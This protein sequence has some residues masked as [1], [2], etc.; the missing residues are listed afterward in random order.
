MQ[1]ST[2]IAQDPLRIVHVVDSLERGGMERVVTDLAIAQRAAG[3]VVTVFS[4]NDT[5]GF[6]SELRLAGVPVIVAGKRRSF[7]FSVLRQLRDIAV[8]GRTHI[9]HAHNFTPNYYCAAA[10]LG[11]RQAP[12][13][14]VTCHDMGTRLSNRKLRLF[15][16]LSLTKT[17][18]V[19]MV[20]RQV[21]DRYVESGMVGA[22]RA[23]TIMSGVPLERFDRSESRRMRAFQ[24]LDLPPAA[25][26]IGCVGRLV[27]IKNHRLLLDALPA[28]LAAHSG[29]VLVLVG[30]GELE[31]PL[32]AQA[33]A[34]QLDSK[35][36]FVGE[37]GDVAD[38]LPAFDIFVLPSSS[39]GLSIALLEAC[40]S[41]CAVVATEVGGNPQI[42]QHG[43]NGL[44]VPPGD[45]ASLRAALDELLTD[46]ARRA[47]FGAAAA[48]WA[49]RNASM[50]AF[51]A[52]YDRFYREA[53]GS[54]SHERG[55]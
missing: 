34:L 13:L 23:R 42:I 46:A 41:G 51:S 30:G 37:R 15:Y 43:A 48:D 52:R 25:T 4:I 24:A 19:A 33:T 40:A 44:L 32:R 3:H 27:P 10:L 50:Q 38:L 31:G 26:V 29:V 36:R 49:V 54:V 9:L 39:E 8:S 5:G 20:S 6:I 14:V 55:E 53:L 22:A 21:R 11:A 2:P 12:V 17:R 16:R 28:L 18:L 1:S 7:D 35:V 45:V 47:G